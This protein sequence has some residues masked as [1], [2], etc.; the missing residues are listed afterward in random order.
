MWLMVTFY[1]GRGGNS[2]TLEYMPR[3][4]TATPCGLYIYKNSLIF[5]LKVSVPLPSAGL[6]LATFWTIFV[7]VRCFLFSQSE[8]FKNWILLLVQL[9][10]I[11]LVVKIKLFI[12]FI[13]HLGFCFSET[14][15]ICI[16][17]LFSPKGNDFFP[18]N[19]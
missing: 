8:K 3:S 4:R 2:T 5:A 12:I 19:L 11:L 14:D 18:V 15:T 7:L 13:A 17:V 9:A 16:S 10:L 1:G 6:P